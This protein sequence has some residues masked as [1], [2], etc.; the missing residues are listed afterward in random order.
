MEQQKSRCINCGEEL[1]VDARHWRLR[2]RRKGLQ[3][4]WQLVECANCG[5]VTQVPMPTEEEL[6]AYYASYYSKSDAIDLTPRSGSRYPTLRKLYHCLSGVVDPRDFVH[7]PAG[8]RVLDFGCGHAGYLSDFHQR[9]IAI[10]G[11]EIAADVVGVCRSQ[12]Y[13]VHKVDDFSHIPFDDTEFDVVYLMQVF[14]H[15]RDPH[16]FMQELARILKV[17][18][19]LYLAVPN[20]SS[21]WRKVFGVNWVSG[22][23]APFHLFHYSAKTLSNL[24]QQHGFNILDSWSRTPESWFRLNIKASLHSDET[25]LHALRSKIDSAVVRVP[26]MI[27]LRVVE[28]FVRERDCLVVMLR[29]QAA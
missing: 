14:E 1:S 23:F 13:D 8:G 15:L 16:Q 25:K 9:G 10:S 28:L 21:V 18:G 5:L 11:A 2:D 27:L 29:K 3:G 4:S 17:G 12:G 20:A 26:L 22:W 7:V 19:T 6:A 24:A